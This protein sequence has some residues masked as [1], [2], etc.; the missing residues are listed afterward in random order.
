MVST[1]LLTQSRAGIVAGLLCLVVTVALR[2]EL[3]AGSTAH[4]LISTLRH[5]DTD[6]SLQAGPGSTRILSLSFNGRRDAWRVAWSMNRSDVVAG[7]GQGTFPVAWTRERRLLQL[8]ILQPHSVLLE[9]LGELG[10]V[11]LG[12]FVVALAL[13]GVAV[14]RGASGRVTTAAAAGGLVALLGQAALDWTW[15]FPVLVASAFL[16]AGAAAGGRR[17]PAPSGLATV[18]GSLAVFAVLTSLA[19]PWYAHRLVGEARGT[20]EKRPANAL[21]TLDSAVRWNRWDPAGHELAGV[22]AERLGEDS[23]AAGDYAAAAKLSQSPWLERLFEA[24]AAKAAGD[25]ARA[26]R[27]CALAHRGNPA[28]THLYGT[29]C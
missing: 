16:V 13:I 6:P 2:V 25:R 1:L 20:I 8:Y 12:L 24:R 22:A 11:G 10:A 21:H 23:V 7:Q 28:E 9:L 27:A 3:R 15:S 14:A 18:A 17:G 29:I 26:D 19:A 5:I 4:H